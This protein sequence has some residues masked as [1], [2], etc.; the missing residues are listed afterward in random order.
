MTTL[1]EVTDGLA[2]QI[3]TIDGL[4]VV[5]TVQAFNFPTCLIA[6]PDVPD[7][8][9]LAEGDYTAIF[10]L[11]VLVSSAPEDGWMQALPFIDPRSPQSIFQAVNAD[12]TLGGLNVDARVTGFPRLMGFDEVAAYKAYGKVGQARVIIGD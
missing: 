3:D 5:Q 11:F 1:E 6:L 2:A 10:S 7:F 8:D 4:S 12:R 9:D